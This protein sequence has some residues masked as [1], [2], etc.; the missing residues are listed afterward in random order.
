MS[1]VKDFG[2]RIRLARIA[3]RMKQEELGALI[4]KSTST[5]SCY[6]SGKIQPGIET[7]K[8]LADALGVSAAELAGFN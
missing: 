8:A 4:G 5:I 6:E 2:M 3:K 7:V 1:D